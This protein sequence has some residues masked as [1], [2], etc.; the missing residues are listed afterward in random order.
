MKRHGNLYDK[1]CELSNIELAYR[2]AKAGKSYRDKVKKVEKNKE[3][4][5]NGIRTMLLNKTFHTSEYKTKDIFIPKPRTL[6]ILPFY[7]DRIVQHALLNI[8]IPIWDN[9]FIDQSFSCRKGKG[10]HKA[11]HLCMKHT[12]RFKYVLQCDISKFYPSINHEILKKVVRKK[13]KDKDV[14][15]LIDDIIDSTNT[16]TNVPIGN[17]TSQWL[18][19]LYLNE[20]DMFVKHELRVKN[21]VRYCD[22]FLIFGDSKEELWKMSKKCQ[23]F[24]KSRLSLDMKKHKVYPCSR[25]I[26]FMGYRHFPNGKMLVRKSTAR[27]QYQNVKS[28]M[29]DIHYGHVSNV[30]ALSKVGSVFGWLKHSHSYNLR[31]KFDLDS[32]KEE[33]LMEGFPKHLNSKE[34]YLYI[35]DNFPP[36]L[37]RPVWKNMYDNR[38]S[39]Q[40]EGVLEKEEE[41][42]VDDTHKVEAVCKDSTLEKEEQTFTYYQYEFR[43]DPASDFHKFGFTESEVL[44]NI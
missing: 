24:L 25:G 16:P 2:D 37:W 13:I 36:S 18:G 33:I 29:H 22:D 26:D 3:V 1:I 41:G 7:P 10:P 20:L 11:S 34:D 23:D 14:L 8:I 21:Y 19:N 38:N 40:L 12:L 43:A 30:Q 5:L 4:L 17:F 32:L 28:I 9:L 6:Y 15:W 39:W 27:R 35:K 44:P 31:D 42:I